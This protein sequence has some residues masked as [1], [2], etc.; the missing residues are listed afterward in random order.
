MDL[1][2]LQAPE[3]ANKDRKRIGRGQGSTWGKQAGK[4]M[5]GQNARSGGGVRPGFEGGQM[6]L[7]RR[8][9]KIGFNNPGKLFFSAINV[10]KL[11]QLFEDGDVVDVAALEARS[12]VKKSADGVKV[13]GSG[14]LTKKLTLRVHRI[15]AS[16]RAKVESAGG[17]VEVI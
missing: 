4:G 3:G 6:P 1:S 10:G 13:L 15:S 2:K 14:E 12:L 5:K 7:H 9:P 11:D 8:L 17:T 16:A